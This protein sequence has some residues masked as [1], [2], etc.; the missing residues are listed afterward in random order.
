VQIARRRSQD[1]G[2]C[3]RNTGDAANAPNVAHIEQ[4]AEVLAQAV[5]DALPNGLASHASALGIIKPPRRRGVNSTA[6]ASDAL[7][8]ARI[9]ATQRP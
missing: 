3:P 1:H 9:G 2:Y 6:L 7:R 8:A 5:R 4:P